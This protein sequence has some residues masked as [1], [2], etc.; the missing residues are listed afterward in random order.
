MSRYE[1]DF[2]FIFNR[3]EGLDVNA[4]TYQRMSKTFVNKAFERFGI[5][6]KSTGR[7]FKGFRED[8]A[9]PGSNKI[10]NLSGHLLQSRVIFVV[11]DPDFLKN[12]WSNFLQQTSFTTRI[13]TNEG[14]RVIPIMLEVSGVQPKTL[15]EFSASENVWFSV[16]NDS[17]DPNEVGWKKLERV[18]LVFI[19]M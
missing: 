4:S 2:A 15:D 6:K 12:F 19:Y 18:K 16:V 8:H 17:I 7:Q 13:R 9:I 1:Y 11:V 10:K 5:L 14:Q 3:F